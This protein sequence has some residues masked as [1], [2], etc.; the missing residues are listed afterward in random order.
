GDPFTVDSCDTKDGCVH[1]YDTN[2]ASCDD[3]NDCTL[4]GWDDQAGQCT[5]ANNDL[6]VCDLAAACG[7]GVCDQDQCLPGVCPTSAFPLLPRMLHRE[8]DAKRYYVGSDDGTGDLDKVNDYDTGSW[9]DVE[10]DHSEHGYKLWFEG[11]EEPG[12][13]SGVQ[14]ALQVRREETA[15]VGE[16][17][18]EVYQNNVALVSGFIDA[19]SLPKQKS[20]PVWVTLDIPVDGA[21]ASVMGQLS[22][23]VWGTNGAANKDVRM[24]HAELWGNL[25]AG[26]DAQ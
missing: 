19:T 9:K 26:G 21:D 8:A 12:T 17:W 1:V 11:I 18:I 15:N 22:I 14:V 5:Y 24:S 4:E 6:G 2:L 3:G 16:L 13:V 25:S 23:K 10:L 7:Q 20:N